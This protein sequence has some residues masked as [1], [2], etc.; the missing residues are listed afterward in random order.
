[1]WQTFQEL[2]LKA[3]LLK[4]P[5]NPITIIGTTVILGIIVLIINSKVRRGQS[6]RYLRANPGSALVIL[7]KKAAAN[8]FFGDNIRPV[9]LNGEKA[10][11]FFVKPLVAA[12]YLKP[13]HNVLELYTQWATGGGLNIR[14]RKSK[15]TALE[16]MAQPGRQ[17]CLAYYI[18]EDRYIFELCEKSEGF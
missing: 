10:Y 6:E 4:F 8:E 12:I 16:L 7:A 18:P 14:I 9:R 3:Y 17:Y 1:M 13:G 11:W 5:V 2:G 15:I